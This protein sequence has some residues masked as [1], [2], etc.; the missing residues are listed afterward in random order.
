MSKAALYDKYHSRAGFEVIA[1]S[2]DQT[3]QD[4]EMFVKGDALPWPQLFDEEIQVRNK[5]AKVRWP[6]NIMFPQFQ[7]RFSSTWK[8]RS[9]PPKHEARNW[10][11][12]F[13][14]CLELSPKK[15]IPPPIR[16][17]HRREG[18]NMPSLSRRNNHARLYV[19]SMPLPGRLRTSSALQDDRCEDTA[20][21]RT[22]KQ[23]QQWQRNRGAIIRPHCLFALLFTCLLPVV[24]AAADQD[25][26]PS[27]LSPENSP[28]PGH[29][30]MGET[31]D[32]GPRHA[33]SL[34]GNTGRVTFPI[35]CS[36]PLVQQFFNQGI[37]QLHGFWYFEA[38]RSF[39]QAAKIDPDCPMTYFGMALANVNNES[40]AKGFIAEA[41]KR[42]DKA[43]AREQKYIEALD[44]WYKADT[45]DEKKKATRAKNY[46]N[47]I[48]NILYQFP[49]DLEARAFL[50]L[51]LWQHR[52]E[53]G[54]AGNFA[55]DALI[56]DVLA[57]NPY[58]PVH[59][60]RVHLWDNDKAKIAVNSAERCGLSAPGIAHMWH[61][62]GHTYSELQQYF[63]AAWHQEASARTDHAYMI[64]DGIFPDRIHNFAHNNEWLVKNLQYLGRVHDAIT[65]AKN[66]IELPQHPKIN[67]FP[68]DKSA[69]FGRLRLFQIYSQFEL[70]DQLI[71]DAKTQ[72][73]G[74]TSDETEQ[75]KYFRHLGRAY[76]RRNDGANGR[77]QL[78]ILERR[79]ARVKQDTDIAVDEA[80]AKAR[81]EGANAKDVEA[82]KN[83]ATRT[84]A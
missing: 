39:R 51:A 40:R 67:A 46:V 2:L 60:Y 33:A 6:G 38:E 10:I 64:R 74:P 63:D 22:A 42:K 5:A 8:G 57:V 47:A 17:R 81:F 1:V 44:A 11:I 20:C 62:S 7:P 31:F 41:F 80:V 79:L 49:D 45:G 48:E 43:S 77:V 70:W 66:T 83:Q 78:A 54:M 84:T 36:T 26:I 35:T 28:M 15:S 27:A 82:K 68:G 65:L 4:L 69:H 24:L 18:R 61:M 52:S 37:G 23:W 76:F 34:L 19:S 9:F 14:K 59:H 56:N 75:V 58:H 73:L 55:I 50:C 12:S 16:R 32:E 30:M 25:L 13:R 21:P 3:R 53:L 71:A 29:S 72:T